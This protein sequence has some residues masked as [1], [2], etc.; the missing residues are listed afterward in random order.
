MAQSIKISDDELELVR[1]AA[2]TNSRSIAGQVTHWL[3]IGRSIEETP[4]FTYAH[5]QDALKGKRSPDELSGKEQTVYIDQLLAEVSG[6][7]PEQGDFFKERREKG[8]GVGIGVDGAI[9]HQ[10][11]SRSK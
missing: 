5:I 7:T 11:A 8:L 4:E 3:R 6:E 2:A 9:Q 1:A 10:K